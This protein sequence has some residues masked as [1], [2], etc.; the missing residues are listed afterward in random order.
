M[1]ARRKTAPLLTPPRLA[2]AAAALLAAAAAVP[3]LSQSFP[4]LPITP[5][6]RAT[7]QQVAQAGVPL[8]ELAPNAPDSHTVKRGDTLWG[9]SALFLR[10]PWRWPE[11]WGMNMDQ[12]RNPHLI[13]PGQRLVLEKVDGRARLRLAQP[14]NDA[15]IETVRV[16]PRTRVQPLPDLALPTLQ[17][18]LIEP[19]L[20]EPLIVEEG[21]LERAPRIVA[22]PDTRVLITQGDRA[23]ARG[24]PEAPLREAASAAGDAYRIFRSAR[25]LLD[26]VTRA[27]LGYEAQY[28]ARAV[29][30]RGESQEAVRTADGE[31]RTLPV[32][33]SLDVV[34]AREEIRVGDRLLPEPP[35]ELVSYVPR[36]PQQP[37]QGAAVVSMYGNAVGVAG[38]NQI[39]TLNK[40]RADGLEPGHVLA[41]L[42]EGRRVLD[43]AQNGD[44]EQ[45]KLPDER[46]GLLMV[47][48]SFDRLSYA[49]V[50]E[51][52]EGVKVGD[53]LVSPR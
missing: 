36:A 13:Y 10:T 17:P 20:A 4:N 47:F 11:L 46:N 2:G 43:R 21:V 5:A 37:L 1:T 12:V 41:I 26:P 15:P 29:L 33:A 45:I 52:S 35:R 32:P 24:L 7:A 48:R 22:A 23:Y 8:S 18:H 16:S 53:R 27:V 9:I 40:G 30:V 38:Q 42:K 44:R 19:F 25:P 39:V 50:L 6:Q 51:T 14:S 34:S 28:V 3:A 49:L 31:T